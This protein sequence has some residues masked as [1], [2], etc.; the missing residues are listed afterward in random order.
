MS[1]F[2]AWSAVVYETT[3]AQ[4]KDKD[5]LGGRR[6]GRSSACG[7]LSLRFRR[8]ASVSWLVVGMAAAVVSGCGQKGPL[9]LPDARLPG[10]ASAPA[11][12]TDDGG[13]EA[14]AAEEPEQD[15]EQDDDGG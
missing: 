15:A 7:R 4:E 8:N 2:E 1:R 13:G 12:T 10:Q 3:T 11:A 6:G 9:V 14:D 5:V